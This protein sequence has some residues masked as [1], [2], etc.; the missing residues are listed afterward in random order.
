MGHIEV[1]IERI[2]RCVEVLFEK[3]KNKIPQMPLETQRVEH[4]HI[5]SDFY[6]NEIPYI[7]S[8]SF[9]PPLVNETYKAMLICCVVSVPTLGIALERPVMN[10]NAA[11]V[12][13]AIETDPIK[14]D[15]TNAFDDLIKD[16]IFNYGHIIYH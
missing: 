1:D 13:V 8:L 4:Y 5:R 11:D 9:S 16:V 14:E 3:A 6:I 12:L 7:L 2:K 10:K 15:F